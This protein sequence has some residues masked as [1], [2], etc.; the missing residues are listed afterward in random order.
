MTCVAATE[1]NQ[2]TDAI[3]TIDDTTIASPDTE[4][5]LSDKSKEIDIRA[6]SITYK[7]NTGKAKYTFSVYNS[8]TNTPISYANYEF[9]YNMEDLPLEGRANSDGVCTVNIVLS[10]INNNYP[11]KISAYHNTYW[12]LKFV[13]IKVENEAKKEASTVKVTAPSKTV[14]YKNS[15]YFRATIKKDNKPVKNLKVQLKV[16]T[17]SNYKTYTR[18]T[19]TKGVISFNTNRL[20]VGEHKVLVSSTN[21]KYKFT[22]NS[23]ITV[24]KPKV[25][26]YTVTFKLNPDSIYY[27]SKKLKTGDT[28]LAAATSRN[29]QHS[30]GITIGTQIDAGQEGQHS[31][32][33]IKGIVYYKNKNTGEVITRTQKTTTHNNQ[34]LKKLP[35]INGYTPYKAKVWYKKK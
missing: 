30:R 8:T 24:N 9:D 35:W 21:K 33:L 23:K 19:N 2:T 17:G 34:N 22:K 31:T 3:N 15:D 4:D 7:A 27:S 13:N 14:T 18:T 12:N 29:G 10:K 16:Y 26:A 20:S 11:T 5:V 6:E 25:S 32:K 28:L 1:N